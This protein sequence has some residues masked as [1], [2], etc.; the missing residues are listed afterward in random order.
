MFPFL[1]FDAG[2]FYVQ[3]WS[4]VIVVTVTVTK[5]KNVVS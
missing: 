2:K 4:Q 1:L 5:I 3:G